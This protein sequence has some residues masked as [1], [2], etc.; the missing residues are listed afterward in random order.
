MVNTVNLVKAIESKVAEAKKA[1][2][3]IEWTD[4]QGHWANKVIDTF[5]K[6][7]VIEGYGDGQFKPDGNITRAEF[8]TVISRVFDISGGASH[9][10]SLSDISSHW[11]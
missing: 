7:R 10:V 6:L 2:V 11:A 8:V 3:K 4:I 1:K 9:S 5:V